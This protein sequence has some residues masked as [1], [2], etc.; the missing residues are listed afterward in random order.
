MIRYGIQLIYPQ[1]ILGGSAMYALCHLRGA[2]AL[3]EQLSNI[4]TMASQPGLRFLNKIFHYF[5]VMVA[6]SLQ[7]APLSGSCYPEQAGEIVDEV[8]GLTAIPMMHRLAHILAIKKQYQIDAI[9]QT[10]AA[11][12]AQELI[13]WRPGQRSD[14]DKLK[15]DNDVDQETTIQI[16]NSY[17]FSALLVLCNEVLNRQAPEY[18]YQIYHQ[19]LESVLRTA[20]LDGPMAT[21]VWPLFTVGKYSQSPADRTLLRHIF[22]K[23]FNRQH[24]KVVETASN[25][26]KLMWNTEDPEVPDLHAPVFFA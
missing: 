26:M 10:Q 17:R 16:A 19:A 18:R 5:D 14:V 23:L 21:L 8:F 9:I 6:L 22:L 11:T 24:M 4:L 20:A 1:V 25:S 7:Q 12:L 15:D 2:K 13:E 3:L